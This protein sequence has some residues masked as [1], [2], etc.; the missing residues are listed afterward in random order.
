VL[1]KHSKIQGVILECFLLIKRWNVGVKEKNMKYGAIYVGILLSIVFVFHSHAQQSDFPI[2]KGPYLGQ[3]QPGIVPVVFASDVVSTNDHIEMG[4]TWTP[5]GKEFYFA[6][7][8]TSDI[9]SNWAIWVVREKEGK[10]SKPEVAPFS[11]V[12]RDFAP[13]ITPDGKYMIFFR[14]S[15]KK[16][17]ARQGTWIVEK[18]VDTWSEPRFFVD[19]YCMTTADFQTFYFS[20]EHRDNTSRDIAMMTYTNGTFSEPQDLI[21][22]INSKEFDAHEWISVDGS[23]LIFDSQRPGGYD[24]VDIYVSF[25]KADSSWTKGFNL[26]ENINKGH[27]HIPSLSPDGKYIFF[28]SDGDLYWVDAKI[29]EDLKPKELK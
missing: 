16:A 29:I 25:R 2:L 10:W 6:R 8:E 7:S 27:R 24:D 15:S 28:A 1:N 19:A 23:F 14:M 9:D 17:E 18:K 21:G 13:F 5:D 3:K 26:G 22:N 20:T 4:C 11:G 12:Y